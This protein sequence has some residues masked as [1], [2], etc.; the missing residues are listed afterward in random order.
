MDHI[1]LYDRAYNIGYQEVEKY[2]NEVRNRIEKYGHSK[3]NLSLSTKRL[4]ESAANY[5]NDLAPNILTE[6]RGIGDSL[7]VDYIEALSYNLPWYASSAGRTGCTCV[8]FGHSDHGPLVAMNKD[9][10]NHMRDTYLAREIHFTG[11]AHYLGY[12]H[13]GRV[14]INGQNEYGLCTGGATVYPAWTNPQQYGLVEPLLSPVLL[15]NCRTIDEAI[16]LAK[17][18]RYVGT[19]ANILLGDRE[20]SLVVLEVSPRAVE[21]R[22]PENSAIF[23]SNFYASGRLEH[24]D[25]PEVMADAVR[26]YERLKEEVQGDDR[27]LQKMV[28]ILK[29]HGSGCLCRHKPDD[30][31]ETILSYIL[32]PKEKR[33]L[34]C[35]GAPCS[36]SYVSYAFEL[37]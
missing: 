15:S 29:G 1:K 12:G 34:L 28:E 14:W 36:G 20:G 17:K 4:L 8:A 31:M 5:L 16:S 7:G 26:R 9:L 10:Y 24:E 2:K 27:S 13:A 6:I 21:I 19:G 32:L 18:I 33:M 11:G 23:C 3:N 30:L 25:L 37:E 22:E 35:D